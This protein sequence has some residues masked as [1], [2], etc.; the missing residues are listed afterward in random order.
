MPPRQPRRTPRHRLST[1]SPERHAVKLGLH[2]A[3]PDP[4]EQTRELQELVAAPSPAPTGKIDEF[5]VNEMGGQDQISGRPQHRQVR[6]PRT[7]RRGTG[8][9]VRPGTS[10]SCRRGPPRRRDGLEDQAV[11]ALE[12]GAPVGRDRTDVVPQRK[13]HLSIVIAGTSVLGQDRPDFG[14][15]DAKS[16]PRWTHDASAASVR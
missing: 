15:V 10:A 1:A 11:N 9:D 6:R 13:V 8:G 12:Q 5:Q 4:S 2:E 3:Q 16:M 7:D 14:I